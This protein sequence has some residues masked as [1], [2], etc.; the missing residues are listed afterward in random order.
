ME[1][2]GKLEDIYLNLQCN[3]IFG[4]KN[5]EANKDEFL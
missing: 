4:K 5:Y 2:F 3:A 1:I